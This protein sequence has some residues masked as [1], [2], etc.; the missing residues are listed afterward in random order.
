M[1]EKLIYPTQKGKLLKLWVKAGITV[2]LLFLFLIPTIASPYGSNNNDPQQAFQV[3]GKVTDAENGSPLPGVNVVVKGT[4]TGTLTDI[5]GTFSIEVPDNKAVLTFSFIGYVSQE[6]TLGTLREINV[7]L[8][9][10]TQALDE[11][12]VVGYGTQKKATLT[13]AVVS[14][15][16]EDLVVTKNENVVNMLTGKLTG[17]RVS[18]K[19][20]AP[21]DY[22]SVIDIRGMGTPLFVIDGVTRDQAYFARMQAD[23]IESISVL[24]DGSAAIYGL[25]AANG[26]ILITTKSGTAQDGKVDITYSGNY[27]IQQFLNVPHGV[28]ALDYMALRNENTWQNFTNN[29]PVRQSPYFTQANMQPFIDGKPSYDWM[30]AVFN[31]S[32]PEQQQNLSINGGTDKLRYFMNLSYFS[33]EG[34]YSSGDYHSDRWNFR[35]NIDG[36]VTKRLKAKVLIGAILDETNR[37]NGTGWSTYKAAWLMRP[38]VPIY[39][40]DN[41]LYLNGETPGLYDGRN[42]V[43]E[44]NTD[45][46]GYSIS[47]NRRLN[48]TLQLSYDIPGV[49]GLSA[50]G[51]YDY[52]LSLPD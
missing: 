48:G 43:A 5:N 52:A 25:R 6:V 32:T 1:N 19:S 29:Y 14:I 16:N 49:K 18:Q 37:P 38:D 3:K 20:S 39:A 30:G 13:G 23:E 45:I 2:F 10:S 41:S 50:K 12:V 34:S 47:K 40:N 24:K 33:Q 36:Q 4:V 44:V 22:N 21:G 51:S 7:S 35:M 27:S 31:K 42:M 46:V 15:K 11:V 17:V 8:T 9:S 28:E 26:V